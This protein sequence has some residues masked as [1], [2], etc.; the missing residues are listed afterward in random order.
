MT[1]Q[2]SILSQEDIE[3]YLVRL[4]FGSIKE[5]LTT[6]LDRAYR[7]FNRTLHGLGKFDGKPL[8]HKQA[9]DLVWVE[10]DKLRLDQTSIYDQIS[11]DV[12]HKNACLEL[13]ALYAKN[14][15][16]MFIGQAQKWINMTIKYIFTLGNKRLPG[17]EYMYIFAHIPIDNII[18]RKLQQYKAPLLTARW[19][20][21]DDYEEYLAFQQWVRV[22]FSV[23]P[24]DME[25]LL[26]LGKLPSTS[27]A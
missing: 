5:P 24:L 4:Y 11:F 17:F 1:H 25:F 15:H 12:W 23:P 7:D 19:S 16:H 27:L 10:I 8:L 6:C 13:T 9:R 21:I 26:W 3:N 14:N 20:R 2:Q 18:I 22:H